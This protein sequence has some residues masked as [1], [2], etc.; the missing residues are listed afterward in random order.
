M[1]QLQAGFEVTGG[2]DNTA[3]QRMHGYGLVWKMIVPFEPNQTNYL[4]RKVHWQPIPATQPV[5]KKLDPRG[6]PCGLPAA[7]R[8][9]Y[10]LYLIHYVRS[11]QKSLFRTCS[12]HVRDQFVF[13]V[14]Q[15]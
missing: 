9:W 4:S 13:C 11:L 3:F 12:W 6:A 2:T 14:L 8:S 15:I 10:M 5:S 7:S 1:Y